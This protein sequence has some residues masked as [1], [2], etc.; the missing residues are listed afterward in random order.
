MVRMR[1]MIR[2]MKDMRVFR[3]AQF[4]ARCAH[5]PQHMKK[6]PSAKSREERIRLYVPIQVV[7]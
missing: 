5:T 7:T 1:L 3:L 2:W 6:E 4:V